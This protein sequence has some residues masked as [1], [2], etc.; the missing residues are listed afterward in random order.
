MSGHAETLRPYDLVVAALVTAVGAV[1]AAPAPGLGRVLGAAAAG[2][3]ACAGALYGDDFLTRAGDIETK[4]YRPIPSGRLRPGTAA[5]CA[6]ALWLAA[7]VAAAVVNWR[8]L[9]FVAIAAAVHYAYARR[10]KDRGLWGDLAVG[11]SGWT[12]PLLAGACFTASWPPPHLAVPALALG[13]QGTFS[14]LLLALADL[15]YDRRAGSGTLPVRRGP[16]LA[17][18]VLAA[19]AVAGWTAACLTPLAAG[20]RPT[21]A[22]VV[23]MAAA[24][25][26][27]AACL[28]ELRARPGRQPRPERAI[29]RHLYERLALPGA[30]W[31]L[32]GQAVAAATVTAAA[33]L[34]VRLAPRPMLDPGPP[35]PGPVQ[36]APATP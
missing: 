23:L 36:E 30:L 3:V 32:S 12:C 28:A 22:F 14:N 19:L 33:A 21:A 6:V 35:H 27:S 9:L 13:L 16:R 1:L 18:R 17:V 20:H 4:P 34:V 24:A 5:G 8:S 2:L 11:A 29:G 26:L 31:A 10:L 25:V 15:P 7:V